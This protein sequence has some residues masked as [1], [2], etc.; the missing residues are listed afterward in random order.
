MVGVFRNNAWQSGQAAPC[1]FLRA[2]FSEAS[3]GQDRP[4]MFP[5]VWGGVALLR[6]RRNTR[7]RGFRGN[8]PAVH[9]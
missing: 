8:H 2:I 5:E 7:F 3:R 4:T 6:V 1:T 9:S